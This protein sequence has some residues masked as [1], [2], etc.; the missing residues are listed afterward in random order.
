MKISQKKRE[1][2]A[3]LL[4]AQRQ[5]KRE[6]KNLPRK[7]YSLSAPD[8]STKHIPSNMLGEGSTTKNSP[9]FYTGEK[10]IG[11]A[12]LHKSNVVPVFI[13]EDIIDISHMRR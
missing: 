3:Q 10:M 11:I 1:A 6:L 13:Q 9:V 12:Q 2:R 4:H 8:R 7:V 5:A